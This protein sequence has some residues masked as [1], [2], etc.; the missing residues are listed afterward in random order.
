LFLDPTHPQGSCRY[1]YTA[2]LDLLRLKFDRDNFV[3][4]PEL[5][6]P[7]LLD[8]I[9]QRVQAA[10]FLPR[11]HDEIALELC[12]A[13]QRTKTSLTFLQSIPAFLRIMEHITGQPQIGEFTGRV[14]QMNSS[15]G[16]KIVGTMISSTAASPP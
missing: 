13:D 5:Y 15:G 11:N 3:I 10:Q 6:E 14:Y 16:T 8:E 7:S 1:R 4:L 12:M 9:L 2:D